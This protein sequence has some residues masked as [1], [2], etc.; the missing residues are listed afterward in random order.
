MISGLFLNQLRRQTIKILCPIFQ[1]T[2]TYC[3]KTATGEASL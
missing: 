3:I 2:E 1:V